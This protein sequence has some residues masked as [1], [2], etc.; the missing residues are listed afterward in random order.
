[1]NQPLIDNTLLALACIL[2]FLITR[3][4]KEK[5]AGRVRSF[6][7]LFAPLV[8]FLNM[9][10]HTV[11]VSIVN[12]KR[13]QAGSFQYS[14][15]FYGLLLFG[16]VFIIVSGFNIDFARKRI[17]GDKSQGPKIL[18]LNLATILLFLPLMFIN[19]IALLPVIASIVSS[20]ALCLMKSPV[21]TLV[22]D[23]R[24]KPSSLRE[25]RVTV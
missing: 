20:V 8:I 16:I 2:A 1:M 12:I 24:N 3:F 10:A 15:S 13:F 17:K 22:Y 11:A 23:R 19:P 25:T 14:F 21:Q 5:K 4:T 6:F 9:W 7:L 18:W